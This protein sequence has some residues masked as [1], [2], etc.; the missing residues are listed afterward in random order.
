M[1]KQMNEN[2]NNKD[3]TNKQRSLESI[4]KRDEKIPMHTKDGEGMLDEWNKTLYDD[5]KMKKQ[6]RQSQKPAYRE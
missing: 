3:N 5:T 1:M 4:Y 2:R 6:V